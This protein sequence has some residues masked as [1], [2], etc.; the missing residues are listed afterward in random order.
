[1]KKQRVGKLSIFIMSCIVVGCASQYMVA[2]LQKKN[3]KT[4]AQTKQQRAT[5]TSPCYAISRKFRL[6]QQTIDACCA[7][8][9]TELDEALQKAQSLSFPCDQAVPITQADIPLTINTSGVY[10]LA[11]NVSTAAPNRVITINA[12]D[13]TIDL[14]G[15]VVSGGRNS[16]EISNNHSNIM[17]MNGVIQNAT[18]NNTTNNGRGIF[19]NTT[20]TLVLK[21]LTVQ[22]NLVGAMFVDS[23]GIFIDNCSIIGNDG[24]GVVFSNSRNANVSR[25][26]V[27]DNVFTTSF[28][29]PNV[30]T[31]ASTA[32]LLSTS[33]N[34]TFIESRFN[35]NQ[36]DIGSNWPVVLLNQSSSCD[37]E[38][39]SANDNTNNVANQGAIGFSLSSS[40]A[41]HFIATEVLNSNVGFF[42]NGSNQIVFKKCIASNSGLNGYFSL[43]SNCVFEDCLAKGSDSSNGFFLILGSGVV[44]GCRA[45]SNNNGF[46]VQQG[47]TVLFSNYAENNTT[48]NY[49]FTLA[50]PSPVFQYNLNTGVYTPVAPRTGNPTKWDNISA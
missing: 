44:S 16:I 6:L 37:F 31:T 38:Q 50:I 12:D 13:V 42:I 14:N 26:L 30:G 24:A 2:G 17:L 18:P 40:F 35:N 4:V 47:S 48:N 8:L 36:Q 9:N 11:E 45:L 1:M 3:K 33:S 28:D 27:H 10:C 25:L 15:F 46:L 32:C 7:N 34:C 20:T 29:I 19:A 41:C 49:T 21:N 43:L 23:E 39:C 22:D 5:S